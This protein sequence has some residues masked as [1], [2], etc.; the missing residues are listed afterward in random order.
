MLMRSAA[1]F[2]V[3][4]GTAH[5]QVN[6][7]K[8]RVLPQEDGTSGQFNLN[9]AFTQGNIDFLDFALGSYLA[10]VSGPHLFF[11]VTNVRFAAKRTQSDYQAEPFVDLMDDEAHF[12][13]KMLTH[14]RYNY[15]LTDWLAAEI[16]SQYEFNEFLL[17]DRR[18]LG[19]IGPRF[20]ILDASG[21]GLWFG[22]SAM[23]ENE[24]VIEETIAEGVDP[25]ST[26]VRS[27]NYATSELNPTEEVSW[28][29]TV[30]FQ[31]RVPEFG[32]FR[33][34][35]ETGITYKVTDTF[36]F[37]LDFRVRHDSQVPETA[38][39]IPAVVP[40]DISL[41]NGIAISW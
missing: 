7:E 32:D 10:Q 33:V 1:L 36:A 14:V 19:G 18:L 27:S 11:W 13:N 17:L 38:P 15:N 40:T 29:T 8:L 41:K 4:L 31:P 3:L 39:E 34:I 35:G 28:V 5:A 2:L 9:T 6:I 21:G 22:T 24:R 20:T 23:L 26:V 30:Y 16:Y 12:S 37:T 25:D